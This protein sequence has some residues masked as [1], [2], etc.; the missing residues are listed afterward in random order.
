MSK[1][2]DSIQHENLLSRLHLLGVSDPTLAWFKS[3][4]SLRKQVVR[5][6]SILSDPSHRQ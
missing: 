5:I 2:F 1:A 6:G 3:Y 4:L